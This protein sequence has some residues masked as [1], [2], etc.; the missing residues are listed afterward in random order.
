M[1]KK[2]Q[3]LNQ[4]CMLSNLYKYFHPLI[5]THYKLLLKNFSLLRKKEE[6]QVNLQI[7]GPE[8]LAE[9]IIT[10][11]EALE[12]YKLLKTSVES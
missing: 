1:E 8:S 6:T 12:L 3:K 5:V 7:E 10:K 11:Q 4:Y 2:Y 9:W